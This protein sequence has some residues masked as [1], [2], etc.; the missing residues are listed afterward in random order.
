[1]DIYKNANVTNL[2]AKA[3]QYVESFAENAGIDIISLRKK[4]LELHTSTAESCPNC[5]AEIKD[6][7]QK[8]CVVCGVKL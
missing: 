7:T 1:M 6:S 2:Q 4:Y 3:K 8:F 5:H